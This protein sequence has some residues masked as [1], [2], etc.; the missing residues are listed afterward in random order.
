MKPLLQACALAALMATACVH[1]AASKVGVASV[2]GAIGPATAGYIDRAIDVSAEAGASCLIVKLDT[3]GGLLAST[4]EIVQSLYAAPLPVVVYVTPPGA[5]AGSAGCFITLA[6]DIAAMAPNTS[7]GA[8]HPVTLGGGGGAE[9][10]DATM[11]KKIESFAVTYIE[12]I[13]ARRGR[14]V[15]WARTAVLDSASVTAE[16]ALELKVIDLIASDVADLLRQLDGRMVGGRTLATAGAEIVEV[17]MLVRE[18]VFQ[19][20]WRPE[21]MFVLMLVA[22]YGIVGELSNPG[23]ILPGVVGAIALILVLYMGAI[24]P[25]NIAGLALIVLAVVLFVADVLAATHGILT[26]GGIISFFLGALMLFDRAVPA[27]RLSLV[28]II[29]A[30]VLT[31]LFFALVVGAGIRAQFLP[32]RVGREALVGR[33]AQALTDVD[34]TDG[35]VFIEGEDWRAVSTVPIARGG[36]AEIVAVQGLLLQVKP[37]NPETSP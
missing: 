36:A 5:T 33:V 37:A 19:M 6:A 17:P 30:T 31:G 13:A 26:I 1:G 23:A 32:K 27:F 4:Q 10:Q 29:P 34:A 18:Q 3:P 14:N 9:Q 2:T 25:V 11:A 12:S 20:L 24:L 21:V 22:I 7:I 8:A 16:K 35:R 15:E 28:L